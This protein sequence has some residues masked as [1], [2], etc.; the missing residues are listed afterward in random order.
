VRKGPL[1]GAN[2]GGGLPGRDERTSVEIY[3]KSREEKS[4]EK[5]SWENILLRGRVH[6][7]EEINIGRG[8]PKVGNKKRLVSGGE[9]GNRKPSTHGRREEQV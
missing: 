5:R 8:L 6:T 7:L 1:Q 3:R 2:G 9:E 4:K